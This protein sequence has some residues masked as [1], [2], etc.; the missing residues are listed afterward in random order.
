L[1]AP[2]VPSNAQDSTALSLA[3]RNGQA[4]VVKLLL[5]YTGEHRVKPDA[6]NN[7]ALFEAVYRDH[8][9]V[10]KLLLEDTTSHCAMPSDFLLRAANKR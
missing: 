7:S 3:A 4:N 2:P 6:G 1:A 5:D 8:R 9:K 10:V